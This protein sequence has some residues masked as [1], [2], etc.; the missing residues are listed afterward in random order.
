[1]VYCCVLGTIQMISIFVSIFSL[2]LTAATFLFF[3]HE[4]MGELNP[5]TQQ[6]EVGENDPKL[7]WILTT[8]TLYLFV[9]IP[10]IFSNGL[11]FSVTPKTAFCLLLV[12]I[13]ISLMM[14][15]FHIGILTDNEIVPGGLL[16]AITN[17]MC[18]TAPYKKIWLINLFSI[19]YIVVKLIIVYVIVTYYS[20]LLVDVC[21]QPDIF[22]CFTEDD[23]PS[24]VTCPLYSSNFDKSRFF[25]SS[26][27]YL[28]KS[29]RLCEH[30]ESKNQV[31]KTT[32]IGLIA[33]LILIAFPSGIAIS[34]FTSKKNMKW[35]DRQVDNITQ[36]FFGCC[37]NEQR[38]NNVEES[39]KKESFSSVIKRVE[40]DEGRIERPSIIFRDIRR[41]FGFPVIN[42]ELGK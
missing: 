23:F 15:H 14:S 8:T 11:V 37:K 34:N 39:S 32:V 1:M 17:V 12:E 30:N 21:G 5:K 26:S 42:D 6:R 38:A 13:L 4:E 16:R 3:Q 41:V 24:N 10:R 7:L 40:F 18:P 25:S 31:L 19:Q 22:R 20:S 35:V 29:P 27:S 9:N 28:Y 33:S 36:I 2:S